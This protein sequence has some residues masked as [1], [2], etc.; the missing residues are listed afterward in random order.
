MGVVEQA[1]KFLIGFELR[2][3]MGCRLDHVLEVV[4][5]DQG[6]ELGH[7]PI[8]LLRGVQIHAIRIVTVSVFM[9]HGTLG[10]VWRDEFGETL[11]VVLVAATNVENS[12]AV[13]VEVGGFFSDRIEADFGENPH[14]ENVSLSGIIESLLSA[15]LPCSAAFSGDMSNPHFTFRKALAFCACSQ[16][17]SD[18]FLP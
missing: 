6:R 10:Q 8:H 1:P 2:L 12:W 18:T 14:A 9:H 13:R 16:L 5:V 3:L 11:E 4:V 15:L 17:F 7:H